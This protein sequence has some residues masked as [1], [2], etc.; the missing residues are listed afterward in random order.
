MLVLLTCHLLFISVL[1]ELEQLL[2]FSQIRKLKSQPLI[3]IF[4]AAK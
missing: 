1:C 4:A 3:L 2:V